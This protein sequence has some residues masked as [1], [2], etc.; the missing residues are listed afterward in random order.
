MYVL[1]DMSKRHGEQIDAREKAFREFVLENNH[2]ITDL[3]VESTTAIRESSDNI[4]KSSQSI[5]GAT[6]ILKEVRNHLIS[7]K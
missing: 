3:V 4:K 6:D 5:Q 2:K 1:W 7:E